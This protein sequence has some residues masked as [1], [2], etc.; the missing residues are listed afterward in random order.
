MSK[1]KVPIE[2]QL[3]VAFTN[4][5]RRSSATLERAVSHHAARDRQQSS[6]ATVGNAGRVSGP[7]SQDKPFKPRATTVA[8]GRPSLRNLPHLAVAACWLVRIARGG[9]HAGMDIENTPRCHGN[10]TWR[11]SS[12]DAGQ[13]RGFRVLE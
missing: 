13:C 9:V 12:A 7:A 11:T 8:S 1:A 5:Q 2:Q 3:A 4:T 6:A 10:E